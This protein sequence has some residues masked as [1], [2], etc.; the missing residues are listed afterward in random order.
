MG[1]KLAVIASSALALAAAT[2][3]DYVA[4]RQQAAAG[5]PSLARLRRAL[6]PGPFS[7]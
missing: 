4:S 7:A 3:A 5:S 1:V 6:Q 2:P